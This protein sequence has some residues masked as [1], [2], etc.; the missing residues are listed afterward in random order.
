MAI[1]TKYMANIVIA[2]DALVVRGV[3]VK[4]LY[5]WDEKFEFSGRLFASLTQPFRIASPF[6]GV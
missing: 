2:Y 1:Y 6:G 5:M 4:M 3:T